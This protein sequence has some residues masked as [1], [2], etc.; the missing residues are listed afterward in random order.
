MQ[1]HILVNLI[2]HKS[3]LAM[4]GLC[5]PCGA[6]V[7][8]APAAPKDVPL[9][10][11]LTRSAILTVIVRM[12]L[13]IAPLFSK[14]VSL[15]CRKTKIRNSLCVC[16]VL[17]STKGVIVDQSCV[18]CGQEIRNWARIPGWLSHY[19]HHMLCSCDGLNDCPVWKIG[20]GFFLFIGPRKWNPR[21]LAPVKCCSSFE[22]W[23]RSALPGLAWWHLSD[24][25]A[26]LWSDA[27]L[28]YV[29]HLFSLPPVVFSGSGFW[30]GVAAK[31]VQPQR[32]SGEVRPQPNALDLIE[33]LPQVLFT[34]LRQHMHL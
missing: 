15:D 19:F 8:S 21:K 34:C 18:S 23:M 16:Y 3:V 27:L 29:N 25:I 31:Y 5:L 12:V 2:W 24:R 17:C 9:C 11:F 32:G 7:L 13:H 10:S 26:Y 6:S 22:F 28:I 30:F 20:L 33:E 1:D 14:L 4:L